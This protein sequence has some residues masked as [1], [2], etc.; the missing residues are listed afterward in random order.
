MQGFPDK[1]PTSWEAFFR[2]LEG[3]PSLIVCDAESGMLRGIER[4][5]GSR[6]YDSPV[7]WLCHKHLKLALGKLLHR[8]HAHPVLVAALE[9]AFAHTT[10]WDR[11]VRFAGRYPNAALGRWLSQPDPTWWSGHTTRDERIAWQLEQQTYD[12]PAST[13]ALEAHL[14]WLRAKI[15]SRSFALRNRERTNRMLSLI[16]L[17]LNGQDDERRY[18]RLIRQKLASAGG[19]GPERHRIE[20]RRGYA[21]LW[22]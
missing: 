7:T 8:H 3:A 10:R 14:H 21:S 17:H 13:G 22:H 5:F 11:F 19:R 20:D 9:D 12:L 16:Q 15:K 2:E 4:A 1:T 18:S 6:P